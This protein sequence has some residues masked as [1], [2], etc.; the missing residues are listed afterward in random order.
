M[1][2]TAAVSDLL[3]TATLALFVGAA[4]YVKE[5]ALEV[6]AIRNDVQNHGE[7]IAKI[8]GVHEAEANGVG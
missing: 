1:D 3:R 2:P 4:Y 7:R 5:L 8:E 6:R